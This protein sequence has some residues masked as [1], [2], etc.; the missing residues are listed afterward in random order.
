M[1]VTCICL[2]TETKGIIL[3]WRQAVEPI[4]I[5]ARTQMHGI[6]K[7]RVK[8]RAKLHLKKRIS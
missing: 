8:D 2:E 5:L 1:H 7:V 6:Q 4:S 3:S